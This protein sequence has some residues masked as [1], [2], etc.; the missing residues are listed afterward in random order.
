MGQRFYSVQ[1]N[2]IRQVDKDT[3]NINTA[4][5]V[6]KRK[7]RL[8]YLTLALTFSAFAMPA[9]SSPP[10]FARAITLSIISRVVDSLASNSTS[11]SSYSCHI[12]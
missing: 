1:H 7:R 3:S 6:K 5:I 2:G 12:L 4:T 10:C 9:V 11:F 8:H